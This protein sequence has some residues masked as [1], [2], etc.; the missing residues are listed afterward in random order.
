MHFTHTHTYTKEY[1]NKTPK[2]HSIVLFILTKKRATR[3]F[4]ENYFF[5]PVSLKTKYLL[6]LLSL[7]SFFFFL[8]GFI[9]VI[10]ITIDCTMEREEKTKTL[11]VAVCCSLDKT[12]TM[13]I[14]KFNRFEWKWKSRV[15]FRTETKNDSKQRLNNSLLLFCVFF[16]WLSKLRAKLTHERYAN[17][18]LEWR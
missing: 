4:Y 7:T 9:V 17:G 2:K 18:S 11:S 12:P 16:R 3:S 14:I 1:I 10:S 5:L 6:F 15:F 13:K 8:F